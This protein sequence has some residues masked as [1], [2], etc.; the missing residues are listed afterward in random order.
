MDAVR[1]LLQ[2]S[3]QVANHPEG[4]LV[5][6]TMMTMMMTAKFKR[7]RLSVILALL[8]PLHVNRQRGV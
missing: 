2:S 6:V 4:A 1:V 5:D 7:V 8:S 3:F